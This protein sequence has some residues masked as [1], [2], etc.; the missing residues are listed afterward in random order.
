MKDAEWDIQVWSVLAW[1][2]LDMAVKGFIL[3]FVDEKFHTDNSVF[4]VCSHC[5]TQVMAV[6]VRTG[7]STAKGEMVRSILFPKP[8]S[9]FKFYQDSVRFVIFLFFTAA[10]GMAYCVHLYLRRHVS[11]AL[12]S[13]G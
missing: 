4:I 2:I 9:G 7:F 13:F 1:D 10:L 8:M 5:F 3:A 11:D 6:V 12:S